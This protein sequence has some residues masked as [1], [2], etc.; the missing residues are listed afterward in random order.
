MVNPLFKMQIIGMNILKLIKGNV[1][2]MKTFLLLILCMIT[3]LSCEKNSE[4]FIVNN[5]EKVEEYLDKQIS[6]SMTP[7]IQY[8]VMNSNQLIFKYAGGW[9]DL[10]NKKPMT[11]STTMMAYSMTKPITAAAILQLSEKDKL[12]LDDSITMYFPDIPYDKAITIRHLLS[13]TSGIPHPIPLKW[14]HLA[15]NSNKFDGDAALAKVLKDNP[16]TKFEAGTKYA[17]SNIS[18]WLLGKIIEKTSGQSYQAYVEEH[19][20][21][22]LKLSKNEMNFSISN[23]NNHAKGYL[24]RY[25][26]MNVFKG[27]LINKELVGEY[28]GK[29]LHINSHYTNGPAFGGLIG[30]ASGFSKFLQDQL[31][32][33]SVLFSKKTSNLFYTQQKNNESEFVEMTLGWHIGDFEGVRYFYKEGGGGGFHCE[34]RIYP[35]H[36]IASIIMVNKTSFNSR[37]TL[38]IL[39]K[40]FLF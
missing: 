38:N 40:E 12:N 6:R 26:F 8:I 30:S 14:V 28:E 3:L 1:Q 24:A 37:K 20:L 22:P 4:V 36:E 29:W 34:M 19:I 15:E 18:Y 21:N 25:S 16:K 32:N 17:Y 13:Q 9:A 7:R 2:Q 33:E 23:F 11:L 39:D 10:T 27:F 35:E 5:S 31:K